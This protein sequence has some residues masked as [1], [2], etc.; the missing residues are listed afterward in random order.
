MSDDD[1]KMEVQP[2]QDE[3]VLSKRQSKKKPAKTAKDVKSNKESKFLSTEAEADS[4]ASS[5]EDDDLSDTNSLEGFV[6]HSDDSLGMSGSENEQ[7]EDGSMHRMLESKL[8]EMSDS[9]IA[10][11]SVSDLARARPKGKSLHAI[12]LG[13]EDKQVGDHHKTKMQ[14][15]R[16]EVAKAKG[17][18]VS[19]RAK[20][21]L[22]SDSEETREET[23]EREKARQ[24]VAEMN[25]ESDASM[26]Q[27]A[28]CEMVVPLPPLASQ[29]N[30]KPAAKPTKTAAKR[31]PSVKPSVKSSSSNASLLDTAKQQF[32]KEQTKKKQAAKPR[33]SRAKPRAPLATLHSNTLGFTSA[34]TGSPEK[35][36]RKTASSSSSPAVSNAAAAAHEVEGVSD[37]DSDREADAQHSSGKFAAEGSTVRLG[38][39]VCEVVHRGEPAPVKPNSKDPTKRDYDAS[40]FSHK[41]YC[42]LKTQDG[43]LKMAVMSHELGP[44]EIKLVNLARTI[45][46]KTN[47]DKERFAQAV[48]CDNRIK[49]SDGREKL[50][51]P[52][53]ILNTKAVAQK[54]LQ[55]QFK[56]SCLPHSFEVLQRN[57]IEQMFA[58]VLET[59]LN[60]NK[61]SIEKLQKRY[62]AWGTKAEEWKQAER[63][64]AVRF[65]AEKT[66]SK[67]RFEDVM[68]FFAVSSKPC[69][70]VLL[71]YALGRSKKEQL[72]ASQN[73][74]IAES[75][76][77]PADDTAAS[78]QV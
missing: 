36:K 76:D 38:R 78:T 71:R 53:C 34:A 59:E 49:L 60:H 62:I 21:V 8:D 14:Q 45:E 52:P 29:T 74:A 19:R 67:Q 11:S 37:S 55:Q 1:Q 28:A 42:T 20:L 54:V 48:K 56:E 27:T 61:Y 65:E 51:I 2:S 69:Q 7:M 47:E 72:E 39:S 41:H 18:L 32:E 44:Y 9:G 64:N 12:K 35:K 30:G 4:D 13:L 31:K 23:L 63:D 17:A 22:G 10:A 5:D 50:L 16:D 70:E 66:I 6:V 26:T 15:M 46:S 58:K 40:L 68:R 75:G 24:I 77:A 3:P 57:N 43:E 73:E 33:K 25:N